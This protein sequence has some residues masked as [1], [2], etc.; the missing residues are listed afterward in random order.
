M[1]TS[2]NSRLWISNFDTSDMRVCEK[3]KTHCDMILGSRYNSKY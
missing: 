1:T 2:R 3:D